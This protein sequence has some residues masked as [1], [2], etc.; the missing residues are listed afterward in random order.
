MPTL[1]CSTARLGAFAIALA[2]TTGCAGS[3]LARLASTTIASPASTDQTSAPA[4]GSSTTL[5]G[6]SGSS[7]ANS[8]VF[9]P[10]SFV[11]PKA[12]GIEAFSILVPKGWQVT[13]GVQ[14][15]PLFAR[16]AEVQT[17][18]ED[19][20]SGVTLDWLPI[21]DFIYLQAPPG[22]D[23]PVGGNYQGKLFVP[24]ITDPAQ[25]VQSFWMPGVLSELKGAQ[26]ES[27]TP[28]PKIAQVFLQN[29]G[30][31]GVAY[32]YRIRYA[33]E[34]NGQPW[35]RD[36]TFTL[37]F[38]GDPSTVVSWYVYGASTAA[39]PAGRLDQS[40]PL[41]ST[42]LASRTTT[43]QWEATQTL[44]A[45]IFYQG[46]RQEIADDI[47]FGKMLAQYEE[48][49]MQLQQ[50]VIADRQASEDRNA[51][52]FRETLGGVQTYDDPV[53]GYPVELPIG[54]QTYWVNE[55]GEYLAVDEAS[56]DPNTLNDGTWQRLTPRP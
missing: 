26:V 34:R 17:H 37:Y 33:Y 36:V 3:G 56:F 11:D 24:P 9:V 5:D 35:E 16:A 55:K 31:Q 41:L 49:T 1:R 4:D 38:V 48:Q 8:I 20:S 13:G 29:A 30:G 23:A 28:L 6:G 10:H 39:A 51:E 43:P 22:L 47:A 52:V 46:L 32:T 18:V 7:P 2:A 44:V 50:Q 53:N 54:Y 45:Q 27:V 40:T 19:P 21:E 12:R 15:R 42:I 25:F 14:W